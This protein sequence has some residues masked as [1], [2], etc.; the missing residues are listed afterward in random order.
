MT[1]LTA[2]ALLA[3]ATPTP[4]AERPESCLAERAG[5]RLDPRCEAILATFRRTDRQRRRDDRQGGSPSVSSHTSPDATPVGGATGAT[6]TLSA[7]LRFGASAAPIL[8]G[9]LGAL[10][11][12]L[13]VVMAIALLGGLGTA[14]EER[15]ATG[16]RLPRR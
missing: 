2:C 4:G 5:E 15:P 14:P 16:F 11:A 6:G 3:S 13:G 10:A 8:L 7:I 1:V 12:L 9:L